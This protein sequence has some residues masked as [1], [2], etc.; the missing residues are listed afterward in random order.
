[1]YPFVST[2]SSTWSG[3]VI[4]TP[5]TIMAIPSMP[6]SF[7]P[8]EEMSSTSK[9]SECSR[10]RTA[11]LA[12]RSNAS[13]SSSDSS[14]WSFT[15]SSRRDFVMRSI[16]REFSIFVAARGEIHRVASRRILRRGR[17]AETVWASAE[18]PSPLC[19]EG[20]DRSSLRTWS[21]ARTIRRMTQQTGT[22]PDPARSSS[23]C[24]TNATALYWSAQ[25]LHPQDKWMPAPRPESSA[26]FCDVRVPLL[27][28]FSSVAAGQRAS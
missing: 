11:K 6:E 3:S 23:D 8:P 25:A 26:W 20:R 18:G 4:N 12:K 15:K 1:M 21:R 16:C 2:R 10:L 27:L 22:T 5:L 14:D 28:V 17:G 7:P 13:D 19:Q 24:Q 9:V